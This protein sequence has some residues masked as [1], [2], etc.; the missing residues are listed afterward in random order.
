MPISSK[1]L[2]KTMIFCKRKKLNC[3]VMKYYDDFHTTQNMSEPVSNGRFEWL[4]TSHIN[5]VMKQYEEKH[6]DFKFFGAIPIDFDKFESIGI[7]NMNLEQLLKD[8]KTKIGFVFNLDEHDQSGSHWVA[9]FA[10][11]KNNKIYYFDSCKN[12]IDERIIKLINKITKF[13]KDKTDFGCVDVHYNVIN[14][15]DHR[16]FYVLISIIDLLKN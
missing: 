16:D 7:I 5:D 2:L 9:L 8:E 15:T 11:I 6:P 3:F 10:N 14:D 1:P 4:S 13:C 12:D